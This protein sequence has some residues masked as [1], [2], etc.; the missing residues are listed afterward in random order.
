MGIA[1]RLTIALCVLW[2]AAARLPARL[3]AQSRE[4]RVDLAEVAT[5][6]Q[7]ARA[8]QSAQAGLWD[9]AIDALLR[10]GDLGGERLVPLPVERDI[11]RGAAVQRHF[12]AQ[13]LAQFRLAEIFRLRPETLKTYRRRVDPTAERLFRELH[14]R[15]DAA[16]WEPLL[17]RY[18]LSTP[19]A[20]A[21]LR[22][23][24]SQLEAGHHHLS[25][26]A[27]EP[28]HPLLRMSSLLTLE[29]TVPPGA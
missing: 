29:T 24:E 13:R 6:A 8:E 26:A 16:A 9:E 28:L 5:L 3:S 2:T 7:F 23:G 1:V 17:R 12:T 21:W 18:P 11:P 19:A 25:V 27:F 20:A 22:Y 10:A 4:V 14:D 15:T